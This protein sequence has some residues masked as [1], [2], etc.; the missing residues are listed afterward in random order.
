[1]NRGTSQAQPGRRG[2]G[3]GGMNRGDVEGGDAGRL[4]GFLTLCVAILAFGGGIT[5]ARA[6]DGERRGVDLYNG[7]V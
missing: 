6:D 1:M 7:P 4:W 3:P 2:K 5:T